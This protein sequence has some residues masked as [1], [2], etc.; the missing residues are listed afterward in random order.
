MSLPVFPSR[1]TKSRTA[2]SARKA[3]ENSTRR[4]RLFAG[5]EVLEDRK[6]MAVT[7]V[8]NAGVLTFTGDGAND[9]VV[10]QSTPVAGTIDFDDGSGFGSQSQAGV[11]QVIFN[12]NGG[13]DELVV[14]QRPPG[15]FAPSG[16]IQF[17][18]GA[19]SDTLSLAGGTAATFTSSSYNPTGIDSGS[20]VFNTTGGTVNI[21]V[22]GM[23]L[24]NDTTTTGA[25]TTSTGGGNDNIVIEPGPTLA[26]VVGFQQGP[27][28]VDGGDRDDHGSFFSGAN[29]DG[30]KY[31]EQ[32]LD[33]V[34]QESFITG[35]TRRLL[36]IGANG[37]QASAAINSV[38]G[39]SG[40]NLG[41]SVDFITTPAQIAAVDFMDYEAIFVP[42][43]ENNTFGGIMASQ[44]ANLALRTADI[45]AY[46]RAGGGIVALTEQGIGGGGPVSTFTTNQ[47][48]DG[49]GWNLAANANIINSTTRPHLS[50]TGTGNNTYDF[51]Q[52][53]VSGPGTGNFDIDGT[54]GW[55]SYLYLFDSAGNALSQSDDNGGDPGS[56]SG[57]DSN[58]PFT[59]TTAGTYYIGV[60]SCCSGPVGLGQVQGTPVPAG[61][62]YTL[63]VSLDGHALVAGANPIG[64][65]EPNDA[66]LPVVGG[67]YSWL[68]I[69]D[70]FITTD[71]FQTTQRQS[72]YLADAFFA[73]GLA[74]TNLELSNGTPTHNQ[75]NGPAGFNGLDPWVVYPGGDNLVDAANGGEYSPNPSVPSMTV[76]NGSGGDQI[77]TI[78]QGAL[79]E[80][81][82]GGITTRISGNFPTLQVGQKP[83]LQVNAQGGNDSVLVDGS[84]NS[85]DGLIAPLTID[86][87]TGT[88]SLAITDSADMLGDTVDV[89][90]TTVNG[91]ASFPIPY[92]NM[93][94]LTVTTTQG[95]DNINVDFTPANVTTLVTVNS[96]DG[97]DT[98]GV[99]P[100]R[101]RPSLTTR[102]QL[103]GGSPFVFPGDQLNLDMSGTTAP[104]FVDTV[105][106]Q[107]L[108]QSHQPINWTSI[109]T[110]DVIDESGPIPGVD[111][112]DLYVRTT[113]QADLIVF[114]RGNAGTT[115]TRVNNAI[116]TFSPTLQIIAYGRE[117]NDT[118]QASNILLPV[119]FR[120]EDGDDYM[121]G[122][123]GSDLLVGGPGN[124]RINGSGGDNVIWGDIIDQPD[125]LIGGNDTLSALGGND[126]FYAGVGDD[127]VSAGAG[128]DYV[129]GSAGNDVL[130]GYDGNDRIYGGAGNDTLTGHS[131]NDLISGGSGDDLVNGTTGNDV[132]FGGTGADTITGGDGNDLLVTGSVANES[133]SLFGDANDLALMALLTGWGNTSSRAGLG[134]VTAVDG[135]DDDVAGNS[136]DDDFSF[137][138]EDIVD[139]PTDLNAPL[140][141]TDEQF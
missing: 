18:G 115:R 40:L 106:G 133:S 6:M 47:N 119:D 99:L 103:N 83:S 112:G 22:T 28:V 24:I 63:H 69:P 121:S 12:G 137:A 66:T 55:D 127:S 38:V 32:M 10:I 46:V 20:L 77:N 130:D 9:R 125:S 61:A 117:L 97:N 141:G 110:Y 59:F 78:G 124:D 45:T 95:N 89:L 62:A 23:E 13:Q 16:G 70:L 4:R 79:N 96:G 120:G 84:V 31:M 35:T 88:N 82:G 51:Y 68:A 73:A 94:T 102:L 48:I 98:Y 129:H 27:V 122:A 43:D 87:G 138:P 116:Y 128:N 111:Q 80:T 42:S 104:I 123:M 34:L 1:T 100:A 140:M 75:F 54:N 15:I 7:R 74:I 53:T 11:T 52:F 2:T 90:T 101:I 3:R 14:F 139:A 113:P 57:F 33:F 29:Q 109:E 91:L 114:S 41:G 135:A 136:G 71:S 108:S 36:V 65:V 126:V 49:G 67:P 92:S 107:A 72:T 131:G 26:P 25:H 85:L 21:A 30:W 39:P 17:D 64:E 19:G 132:L 50:I 93:Q 44:V 58:I 60:G 134:V 81:F 86:G 37:G 56:T 76:I 105:G 5:M 8:F 118:I